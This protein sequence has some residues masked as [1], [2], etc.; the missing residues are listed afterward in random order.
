MIKSKPLANILVVDDE[1]SIRRLLRQF[2]SSKFNIH[3]AE[4]AEEA[5]LLLRKNKYELA[6]VDVNMPGKSGKEMFKICQKDY[7]SMQIILMTGMPELADAVDTVKEGA[8]YYLPK[9]IDMKFLL[10]LLNRAIEEKE[11]KKESGDIGRIRNLASKYK[12]I[13]SLGC[14]ISGIV[15]LVE[16]DGKSYAMKALRWNG[17]SDNTPEKLERFAREAEILMKINNRHVVKIFEHNLNKPDENPYII[18][19][20]VKGMSLTECLNKK[21]FNINQKI[22]IIEQIADGIESV[23]ACGVLHRDIKP[24]NIIITDDV[25]VKITDFGVSHVSDSSLTMDDEILGSPSYMAPE[26]F[27]EIKKTD[28]R[29]DIFSIGVLSYEMLTGVMPFEGESIYQVMEAIR[30]KNPVAPVKIAPGIPSWM[31]DIMVKML[32]KNPAGRYRSA[33]EIVKAINLGRSG[34]KGSLSITSR[35]LKSRLFL[36]NIWR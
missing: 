20:Y 31:Q 10:S 28:E 13:R 27:D 30:K 8:F 25:K 6:I 18:M 9:P 15:L 3:A 29:S 14:G 4:S 1:E 11:K 32:D 5:L 24:E 26:S 12:I 35:I 22:S 21:M 17:E 33:G 34:G 36:K 2:L 7:P 16:N 19:E 23:H